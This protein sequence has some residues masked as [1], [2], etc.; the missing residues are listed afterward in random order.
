MKLKKQKRKTIDLVILILLPILSAFLSVSYHASFFASTVLFFGL[1]SVYL[2]IRNPKFI[3][4]IGVFSI[5]WSVPVA[6][7]V[8]ILAEYNNTWNVPRT[9]FGF[10]LFGFIP[11]ED[12]IWC[13]LLTYFVL[14]NYKLFFDIEVN[15]FSRIKHILNKHKETDYK[16]GMFINLEVGLALVVL[17][18]WIVSKFQ[19]PYYYSV[20]GIFFAFVPTIWFLK[21]FPGFLKRLLK[22][23]AL[24]APQFLLFELVGLYLGQ[25]TFT[26]NQF[27]GYIE[28]TGIRFPLEELI[29]WILLSAAAIVV[30]FE[31]I[32]DDR[33]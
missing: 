12:I 25:W 10:R 29:V 14:S 21:R 1:P 19:V 13:A 27:F 28:L 26:S 20:G 15:F 32:I 11:I 18:L 9:V 6:I 7:V 3:R 8:D 2:S 16:I 30:W 33:K 17:L 4:E 23:T 5:L 24:L 31:L 22:L